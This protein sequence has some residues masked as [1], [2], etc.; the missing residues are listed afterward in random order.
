MLSP[1]LGTGGP[2]VSK[3]RLVL[4]FLWFRTTEQGREVLNKS[5]DEFLKIFVERIRE[6]FKNE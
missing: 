4:A 6:K 3:T 1:A 5:L 2:A